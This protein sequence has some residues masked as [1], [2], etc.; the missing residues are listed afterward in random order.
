MPSDMTTQDE[1]E[2]SAR[3]APDDPRKPASP[4]DLAKPS[5]AAFGRRAIHEFTRDQCTDLAAAL[6]YY[7][8][9]ALFPG[10]LALISLL[11]L[12][13]QGGNVAGTV[14]SVLDLLRDMV[15]AESL[16]QIRPVIEQMVST[17][18]AGLT[19]IAGLVGAV[20]SASGYVG[21]FGR[22]MNRI[23]EVTEGRPVWKLRPLQLGITLVMLLMA[24]VVMIGLVV[25]GPV[26]QAIGDTIG[27]GAQA[28]TVW[29]LAKW[30]VLLAV[31]VL[32][33][34]ILYYATPNVR[35]PKFRWISLG[36][37]VAIITWVAASSIF[38]FY[39]ANFGSYNKTYGTLAGVIVM[40][41]W[42]WITNLALL[43]GAE[44]DAEMERARQ[45]QSGI[46]AEETL[47]LPVR[48]SSGALKKADKHEDIVEEG[49]RVRL[50]AEKAG[51]VP[52]ESRAGESAAQADTSQSSDPSPRA[53][54][55][56]A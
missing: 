25:S 16:N 17:Q 56:D 4:V 38:G 47:Q 22:A 15:P 34:A 49:R 27:L 40:L 31:V 8:V 44:I 21:A 33:V 6:T 23:Y 10:L 54:R 28:V 5:W 32:M 36:A 43:F 7:S 3:P 46:R 30:P 2:T 13:G 12:F 14:N 35:Q 52:P 41:L 26:A 53:S 48:E 1:V 51:V 45:L 20:W 11:G 9:L 42:L 55:A 24:V 18:A 29:E 50:D 37:A 19:L 39:V